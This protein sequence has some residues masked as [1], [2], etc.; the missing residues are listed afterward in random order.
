M[1]YESL[2]MDEHEYHDDLRFKYRSTMQR[3]RMSMLLSFASGVLVTMVAYPRLQ[4]CTDPAV[5][6]QAAASRCAPADQGAVISAA[7]E[8]AV[9]R[10]PSC[11]TCP[12]N[13]YCPPQMPC[14]ACELS[15]PR[16]DYSASNDADVAARHRQTMLSRGVGKNII[17]CKPGE[18]CR[19]SP[20]NRYKV[21]GQKGVTLWMT[22]LS[23]SG[24]TTISKALERRLLLKLGK[25]V[26]NIDGDNLRTGLT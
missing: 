4:P 21:L 19:M 2:K 18:D 6:A 17:E 23:G 9:A 24:K 1:E 26:F 5:I 13:Q 22:G 20:A 12:N 15:C 3:W 10:C 7:I 14:P 11:P 16:C 25:N 8:K